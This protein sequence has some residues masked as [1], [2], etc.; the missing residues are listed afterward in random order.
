MKHDINKI[1]ENSFLS[2]ILIS[3]YKNFLLNIKHFKFKRNSNLFTMNLEKYIIFYQGHC[4][5]YRFGVQLTKNFKKKIR[6][7]RDISANEPNSWL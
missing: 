2:I 6:L 3:T 1:I 4:V 7:S 5:K